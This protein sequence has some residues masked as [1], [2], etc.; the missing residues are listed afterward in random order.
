MIAYPC[1]E[2]PNEQIWLRCQQSP[3]SWRSVLGGSADC[4]LHLN[5][6]PDRS[7]SLEIPVCIARTRLNR[8]IA[9]PL[10]RCTE[11]L[12]VAPATARE[13]AAN[14]EPCV[15]PR[16]ATYRQYPVRIYRAPRYSERKR[17]GRLATA[18]SIPRGRLLRVGS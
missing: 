13:P 10:E 5:R 15:V 12:G 2:A 3:Q 17:I 7:E 9:A 14:I 6:E 8:P 1:L 4:E 11:L 18:R 16:S